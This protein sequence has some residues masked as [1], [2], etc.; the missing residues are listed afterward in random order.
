MQMI[1]KEELKHGIAQNDNFIDN[2]QN[3]IYLDFC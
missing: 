1:L 3:I 2:K